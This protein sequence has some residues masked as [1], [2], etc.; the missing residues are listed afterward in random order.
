MKVI[1]VVNTK[2]GTGKSTIAINLAVG[3]ANRNKK[4]LLIDTDEIQQSSMAFFAIRNANENLKAISAISLPDKNIH[5]T[6]DN[7]S[8]FDYV[9]IDSGLGGGS[10]VKSAVLCS[11][12][13]ML[14]IPVKASPMDLWGTEDT[15][16]ILN[17]CRQMLDGYEKNYLITNCVSTNKRVN[18]TRDV[19]D[20]MKD[21]QDR[22]KIN[23][24]ANSLSER[25]IFKESLAFGMGVEEYAKAYHKDTKAADELNLVI[26]EI[27][28][29]LHDE[30]EQKQ[31][32]Q[33]PCFP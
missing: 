24:V 30:K 7:Y 16:N 28:S 1:S 9:I 4:I 14:L 18:L 11:N 20:A 19:I 3:L 32:K 26:D 23:V 8:D 17:D 33:K 12:R 29:I 10:I 5:R 13:G 25:T 15:L 6:I 2:G 27:I 31:Y 21:I 22:Y